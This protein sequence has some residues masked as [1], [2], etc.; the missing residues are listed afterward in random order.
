V[1]SFDGRVEK[2]FTFGRSKIAVDFD[3]FNLLNSD[4]VLGKTYDARLTGALGYNQ[5]REI[6]QPRIAR[7]GVRFNF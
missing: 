6:M 3:V 1:T 5:I 4:V 2:A 7:L